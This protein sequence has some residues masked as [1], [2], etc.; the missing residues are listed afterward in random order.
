MKTKKFKMM[1]SI[2]AV[3]MLMT[4]CGEKSG[5]SQ[6]GD[7]KETS[8]KEMVEQ[9]Y[10]NLKGY[11]SYQVDT[12]NK[13][14]HLD[15]KDEKLFVTPAFT[16]EQQIK[17]KFKDGIFY[18]SIASTHDQN[19]R[20]DMYTVAMDYEVLKR[21][22][23]EVSC[24]YL[25]RENDKQ[26]YLSGYSHGKYEEYGD[27]KYKGFDYILFL[28]EQILYRYEQF[29]DYNK[30]VVDDKIVVKVTCNDLKG[31]LEKDI[32]NIKERK[33]DYDPL[34]PISGTGVKRSKFEVVEYDFTYTMDKDYNLIEIKHNE[35]WDHGDGMITFRSYEQSF[36]NINETT[37]NT[38]N[39]DA[40]F[41]DLESGKLKTNS[42]D[43][44]NK[45]IKGDVIDLNFD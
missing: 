28:D 20:D 13:N 25:G 45:V 27:D 22:D 35:K 8:A 32:Q 41:N 33:P 31:F 17:L 24:T 36:K 10:K 15:I 37:V 26:A 44:N 3:G 21:T 1:L 19:N 12:V 14:N 40:V 39:I 4:G 2:L 29:F 23:D 9:A 34:I 16:G 6:S 7:N 5:S 30:D 43:G 42:V 11:Q 38:E 18:H